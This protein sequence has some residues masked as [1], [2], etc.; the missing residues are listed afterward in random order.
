[1][2]WG[3]AL[4]VCLGGNGTLV[5]AAANLVVAGLAEKGGCKVSFGTFLRY[6][7]PVTVGSMVVASIYILARYFYVTM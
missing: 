6:G 1:M 7:V 4:S 5:G 3:L 2:W